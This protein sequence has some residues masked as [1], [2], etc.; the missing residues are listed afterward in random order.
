MSQPSGMFNDFLITDINQNVDFCDELLSILT[1][2]PLITES[3][4]GNVY[5]L[6]IST[7][8]AT[9]YNLHDDNIP[10]ESIDLEKL[11]RLLITWRKTILPT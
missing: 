1:E 4:C 5:E 7:D 8:K 3:F 10:A 9:L 6:N 11:H 2:E